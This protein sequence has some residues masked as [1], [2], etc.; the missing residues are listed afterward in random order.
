MCSGRM[1]KMDLP[2]KRRERPHR[3][4]M[5][6]V[7]EYVQ[8]IVCDRGVFVYMHPYRGAGASCLR[9]RSRVQLWAIYSFQLTYPPLTACLWT[10]HIF[11]TFTWV[12]LFY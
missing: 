1:L 4:F 9:A 3:R 10:V 2:F 7:K 5:N 6:V 8:R 12:A 11:Y